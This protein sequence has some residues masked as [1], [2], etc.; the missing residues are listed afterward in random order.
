[1]NIKETL[2]K[3]SNAVSIGNITDASVIA[4]DKLSKYAKTMQDGITVVGEIQ[5]E[6]KYTLMLEAHI[7]EVGFVVTDIDADGFLT[8][9][10]CGGIDLRMLPARTVTIHGKEKITGVSLA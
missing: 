7:D 5:G 9:K 10:N 3:L 8:V 6:G 4:A 1:M 2:F